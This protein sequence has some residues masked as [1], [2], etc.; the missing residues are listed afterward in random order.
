VHR[1]QERYHLGTFTTTEGA[2]ETVPLELVTITAL[3]FG[4]PATAEIPRA[5]SEPIP[6]PP[7]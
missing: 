7:L 6:V 4:Q 3:Y 2:S 1:I 5:D